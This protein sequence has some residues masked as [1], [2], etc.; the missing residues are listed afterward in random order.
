MGLYILSV[1]HDPKSPRIFGYICRITKRLRDLSEN[2]TML[3]F[4]GWLCIIHYGP[5]YEV[6]PYFKFV[7]QNKEL[8]ITWTLKAT[9]KIWAFELVS[10]KITRLI[11]KKYFKINIRRE[12]VADFKKY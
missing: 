9:C 3:G 2:A 5:N 10:A 8:D 4:L 7:D 6:Y 12:A 11:Y 1:M